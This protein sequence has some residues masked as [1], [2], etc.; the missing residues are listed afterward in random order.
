MIAIVHQQK[1]DQREEMN[2]YLACAKLLETCRVCLL[3]PSLWHV[4][5]AD[6][7]SQGHA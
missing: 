5:S 2:G 3:Y 7:Q 1:L 4:A 6:M